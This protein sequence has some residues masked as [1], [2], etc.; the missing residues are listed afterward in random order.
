M[1]FSSVLGLHL[2]M[3][4]AMSAKAN[5]YLMVSSIYPSL[6]MDKQIEDT[7]FPLSD[8]F[9]NMVLESGY[10]HLQATKPDTIGNNSHLIMVTCQNFLIFLKVLPSQTRQ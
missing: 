4:G 10:M 5:L 3:C 2:N 7:L 1:W 9:S 6:F 8:F